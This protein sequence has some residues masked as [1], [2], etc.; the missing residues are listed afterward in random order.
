MKTQIKNMT[1]AHS[2]RKYQLQHDASGQGS[3]WEK[4][5]G[6]HHRFGA[7]VDELI[8]GTM[9][10]MI[11]GQHYRWVDITPKNKVHLK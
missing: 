1:Y 10:A 7:M 11:G 4:V 8:D 2:G 6:D 9:E 3:A 5:D